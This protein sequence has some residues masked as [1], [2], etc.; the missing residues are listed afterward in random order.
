MSRESC[1]DTTDYYSDYIR[2]TNRLMQEKESI[3]V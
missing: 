1:F 3:E 2:G